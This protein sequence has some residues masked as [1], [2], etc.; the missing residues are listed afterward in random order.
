M[1]IDLALGEQ[2]FSVDVRVPDEQIAVAQAKYTPATQTWEEVVEEGLRHPIGTPSL[3]SHNLRGKK[4]A[5][6]TDDWGRPTPSHRV[7]PAVLRELHAAGA[8]AED[9]TILTGTGVH[10]PMNQEDLIRKVGQAQFDKYRCVPHDAFDDANMTYVGL[11]PRGTPLWLNTIVAEADFKVVVGRIAPHNT[12]GYEGGA[13]MITPAV[14]RWLSVLRNHSCNF[15]PYCEYGSYGINPSRADVD[16]IGEMVNLEFIVNFVVNRF[17]EPL[18]AFCGHRI[19]AHRAGIAYGDREVWGA[20]IGRKADLTIAT[21]GANLARGAHAPSP[22]EQAAIGTR[23]R[24]EAAHSGDVTGM[25]G[26]APVPIIGT[27]GSK[28]SPNGHSGALGLAGNPG[29]LIFVGHP[30]GPE[31]VPSAW[32]HEKSSWSFDQIFVEHERRDQ[33]RSPREISDRCKSIRGEYYARRAGYLCDVVF[34]IN[35]PSETV[36]RKNEARFEESLQKAVDAALDR[37]GKDARVLV[38][39]E[40]ANTLPMPQFHAFPE[41]EALLPDGDVAARLGGMAVAAG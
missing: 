35:R 38:L 36:I 30:A 1:R 3:R 31:S 24:W 37:L 25:G 20:E 4:I 18:R 21:L 2:R 33:Q 13:K 16:D 29:T 26:V 6:I 19:L 39:P 15:S 7:L 27:G 32:E 8:V 9:I 10:L 22:L 14:S 41:L 11:S 40:A 12:H 5:L 34:A 23:A 28:G 17:G